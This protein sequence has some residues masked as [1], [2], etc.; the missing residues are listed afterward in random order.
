MLNNDYL[1]K[2]CSDKIPVSVDALNSAKFGA[3]AD[4]YSNFTFEEE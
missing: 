4:I 1:S 3:V 2:L